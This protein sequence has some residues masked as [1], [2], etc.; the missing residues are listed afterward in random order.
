MSSK[1]RQAVNLECIE[2]RFSKVV[3]PNVGKLP[4]DF[5]VEHG[6]E[7]GHKVKISSDEN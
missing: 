5:V 3:S 6:R 7:T 2:C 1:K 4:V